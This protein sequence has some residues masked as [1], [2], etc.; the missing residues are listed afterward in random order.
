MRQLR[1]AI[2]AATVLQA[3]WQGRTARQAMR[4]IRAALTLQRFARG[5][6]IRREVA[7]Q[8]SAAVAIQSAW[9]QRQAMRRYVPDVRDVTLAQ[10][11]CSDFPAKRNQGRHHRDSHCQKMH[12]EQQRFRRQWGPAQ[13]CTPSHLTAWGL[14]YL[15]RAS[16]VS[17]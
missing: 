7:R 6:A 14:A 2:S 12:T 16:S 13:A 1:Q 10:V 3:H 17:F 15:L 9:R 4:R 5:A 11:W 8:R